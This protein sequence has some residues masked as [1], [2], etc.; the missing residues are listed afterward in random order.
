MNTQWG[1]GVKLKRKGSI[2]LEGDEEDDADIYDSILRFC[3]S[4]ER[5]ENDQS[6]GGYVV[7]ESYAFGIQDHLSTTKIYY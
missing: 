1:W 6:F 3:H 2:D 7:I 5:G 4:N